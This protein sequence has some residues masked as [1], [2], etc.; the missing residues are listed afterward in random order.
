[1][2]TWT[3]KGQDATLELSPALAPLTPFRHQLTVVSGLANK[4]ADA[5]GDGGGDHS[6]GPAAWLNAAPSQED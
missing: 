3:P 2:A 5:W 4:P 1:M 6:R